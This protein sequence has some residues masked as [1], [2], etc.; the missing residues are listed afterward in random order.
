MKKKI[1]FQEIKSFLLKNKKISIPVFIA[2]IVIVFFVFRASESDVASIESVKFTD[3]KKSVRATGQVV[4]ETDISLSFNK[5]SVVRSVRAKVGDKVN[6]GMILATLDQGQAFATLT[7][8]KGKLLG[9]EAK[10]NKILEGYSNE[11]I[12][13]AEVAFKNAQTDLVNKKNN[14]IT[15][16]ANAYQTLL[17]SSIAAFSIS[18]GDTQIAPTITGTYVLEKE[19]DIRISTYQGGSWYFDGFGLVNAFGV[20]SS[21]TPQPIGESGLYIQFPTT[22]TQGNWIISI[23]NKK[24][25]NYLTNYNAYKSA[26]EDQTIIV[27]T[28]QS[29]VDQRQAELNLKKAVARNT[30]VDIAKAEVLSAEG[31]LQSAQSLYEDTIIRAGTSGTI[32]K[33]DIKYGELSEIGKPV[34]TLEDVGNLYIEALINEANIA[35]LKM[36]QSVSITFDAFGKDKN[37]TG[38]I[39]HIDPSAETNNGVVNYKIKVSLNEKD[40]TIRPGMNA[41][42]DILAGQVSN[43]L[44]IPYIAINKKDGKYF[45]DFITNE[46]NKKYEDREVQ[47]GFLGDNNLVEITSGLKADDKVALRKD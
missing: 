6:S 41:N 39:A 8:A 11:E 29:L 4:S 34:I 35:Y 14:Q 37:F 21:T 12:I 30:D 27:A 13:L 15:V 2:I 32:T 42:I 45:V 20:V 46:K 33:V 5:A 23:P 1:N 18:T 24:A 40:E 25:T 9:A 16:V 36:G 19:G 44:A 3:L 47:I 10:Y 17:N 28:A 38:V 43:V 26:I 31:A 22:F 7:E